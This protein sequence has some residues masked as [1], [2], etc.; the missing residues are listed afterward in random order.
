LRAQADRLDAAS[1]EALLGTIEEETER[2]NR[3]LANL[4]DMTRLEAGALR[5][6]RDWIDAAELIGAAVAR[7]KGRLGQRA[8]SVRIAPD[9]PLLRVDF[10]L[11]Q[12][13][14][15]NLLDNVAK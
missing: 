2:L 12:Q 8:V 5:L 13:V 1:R 9:M 14:L 3:F 11:F 6:N 10:T 4:L 15:F 7:A